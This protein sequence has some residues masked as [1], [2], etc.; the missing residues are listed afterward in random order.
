MSL[1]V[2]GK[3]VDICKGLEISHGECIASCGVLFLGLEPGTLECFIVNEG[4]G[5]FEL[6][7]REAREVE[8]DDHQ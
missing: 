4:P 7:R 1:T 6:K 8:S 2:V 5:C 3:P